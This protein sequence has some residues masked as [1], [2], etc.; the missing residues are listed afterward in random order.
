[1]TAAV[2]YC[3]KAGAEPTVPNAVKSPTRSI[4]V[5]PDSLARLAAAYGWR[6][7]APPGLTTAARAVAGVLGPRSPIPVNCGR[8]AGVKKS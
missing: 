3:L 6:V 4:G 1:M 7:I 5:L 2:Q 8:T